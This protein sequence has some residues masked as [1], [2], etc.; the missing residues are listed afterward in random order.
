M[1][2]LTEIKDQVLELLSKDDK[3]QLHVLLDE[4]NISEVAALLQD[5]PDEAPVL[6]PLLSFNR[7]IHV[8]RI[9][10]F[11]LQRDIIRALP[12]ARVAE[13]LNELPPDDRVAFLEEL[14][15]KP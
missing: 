3:Q 6:F 1:E 10:D 8:F 13:L 7:G 5:M 15:R 12:P 4:M 2:T 14:P 9:L 11:S